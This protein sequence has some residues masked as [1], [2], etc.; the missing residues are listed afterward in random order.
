MPSSRGAVA[1]VELRPAFVWGR[2]G[3]GLPAGADPN[4]PGVQLAANPEQ[5]LQLAPARMVTRG[6]KLASQVDAWAAGMKTVN[7]AT[8][9]PTQRQRKTAAL[10]Q[11]EARVTTLRATLLT[12]AV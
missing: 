1:R 12:S 7:V 5:A 4:T 8:L 2:C 9:K 6:G 11:L 3:A 10:A